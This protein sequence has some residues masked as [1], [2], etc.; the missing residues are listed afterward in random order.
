MA[1]DPEREP[2]VWL[3]SCQR[4]VSRNTIHRAALRMPRKIFATLGAV[5]RDLNLI[6]IHCLG[7]WIDIKPHHVA[8][9]LG[10]I[11]VVGQLELADTVRLKTVLAPDP[12]HRGNAEANRFGHRRRRSV[13]HLAG[14]L[15]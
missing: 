12:L 13:G 8:E 11:L 4:R 10:E 3:W 5:A 14:R 7:Q 9:L 6:S 1:V 15:L 2:N